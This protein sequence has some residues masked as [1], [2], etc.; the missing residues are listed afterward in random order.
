LFIYIK[1]KAAARCS[2]ADGDKKE[3]TTC[4]RDDIYNS[5]F[6]SKIVDA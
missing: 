1:K 3:G 5:S 4:K 2:L 6:S